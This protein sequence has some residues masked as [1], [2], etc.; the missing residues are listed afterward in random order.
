MSTSSIAAYPTTASETL[1]LM[2]NLVVSQ[3]YTLVEA[4]HDFDLN[5]MLLTYALNGGTITFNNNQ[6]SADLSTNAAAQWAVHQ[7]RMYAP[8]QPAKP[9]RTVI[10]FVMDPNI[11]MSS[12]VTMQVGMFDNQNNTT[13][14]GTGGVGCGVFLRA[15]GTALSLVSRNS[16]G[17]TQ[18]DTVVPQALWNIDPLNGSGASGTSTVLDVQHNCLMMIENL[19]LGSDIIRIAFKIGGIWRYAHQSPTVE[20]LDPIG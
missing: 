1:D 3:P 7:T 2:N 8:Y 11:V 10:T 5:P 19:F 13:E 16:N 6:A 14:G 17:T 18:T 15:I 9:R 4:T 20:I 12:N